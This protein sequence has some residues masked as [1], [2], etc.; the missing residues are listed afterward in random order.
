M[1]PLVQCFLFLVQR[2]IPFPER[3]WEVKA[4]VQ[5]DL[6]LYHNL[7]L[8]YIPGAS[9]ELILMNLNFEELDRVN[10]MPITRKDINELLQKLGFYKKET[11]NAEVP[12]KFYFAPMTC[13]VQPKDAQINKREAERR[14]TGVLCARAPR[15]SEGIK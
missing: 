1:Y 14:W 12:M 10:L 5:K 15:V 7:V 13:T 3:F 4:F 8:K 9:P 11:L 6:P 2:E